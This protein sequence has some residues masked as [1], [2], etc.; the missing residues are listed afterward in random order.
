MDRQRDQ[1][2]FVEM[3]FIQE[4][5]R[6]ACWSLQAF[7]GLEA[8]KAE[9]ARAAEDYFREIQHMLVGAAVVSRILWPPAKHAARGTRLRAIVGVRSPS[10]LEQRTVRNH[11]EHIDERLHVWSRDDGSMHIDV[12]VG[13]GRTQDFLRGFT[14]TNVSYF[15]NFNTET[16]EVSFWSDVID[17]SK[18]AQELEKVRVGAEPHVPS[19]SL[20]RRW[21]FTLKAQPGP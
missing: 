7:A 19:A 16:S 17:L 15:R 20:T 8:F 11:F 6:Q 5:H 13:A 4:L 1:V 2:D 3:P 21:T 14:T 9:P 18:L 10:I 12:N